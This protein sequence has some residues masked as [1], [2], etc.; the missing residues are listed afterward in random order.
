MYRPAPMRRAVPVIVRPRRPARPGH[1]L[2]AGP[3]AAVR[4][5]RWRAADRRDQARPRPRGRPAGRVPGPA[6]DGRTPNA[7]DLEDIREHH[8]APRQLHR[9]RRARRRDPGHRPHRRRAARRR[10]PGGDPQARRHDRPARLRP[11]PGG[12][13]RRRISQGQ[14]LDLTTYPPLFSGDEIASRRARRRTSRRPAVDF[15]L[16]RRARS[17]STTYT[18]GE[19]RQPVRDRARR[20]R[21]LGADASRTR[22][23]PAAQAQISGGFSPPRR[24]TW[25]RS[26]VRLAAARDPGGRLSAVDRATLGASASSPRHPRRPHRHRLVFAFMLIYYRLPGV[27]RASR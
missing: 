7:K 13:R 6:T 10:R 27:S 5:P 17:C 1:Q 25:S 23:A 12:G 18:P 16:K 8:R 22:H 3:E 11:D 9:R 2:L 19:H 14:T 15:A 20:H 26:C 24:T 4:R 21:R